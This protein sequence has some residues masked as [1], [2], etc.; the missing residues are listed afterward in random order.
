MFTN[1]YYLEMASKKNPLN[2]NQKFTT[3]RDFRKFVLNDF[4]LKIEKEFF[5][6]AAIKYK[7][8]AGQIDLILDLELNFT[9]QEGLSILTG[10]KIDSLDIDFQLKNDYLFLKQLNILANQHLLRIDI[11]ELTIAFSDC[12]LII[13]R[14]FDRS[15]TKQ[16]KEI[17]KKIDDNKLAITKG[18][19]SIPYEI[20]IPVFEEKSWNNQL[21]IL[22]VRL[23]ETNQN[24]YFKFWALYF[25]EAIEASIYN[26][27]SQKTFSGELT[28][29]KQ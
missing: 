22:T 17:V 1:T 18:F 24:D 21:D 19:S 12:T 28:M 10:R 9:L 6:D 13:H 23:K 25:E 20:H 26:V 14:I 16:I 3:V 29:I 4:R 27:K 5:C 7:E 15:I 11:E 2:N 8:A